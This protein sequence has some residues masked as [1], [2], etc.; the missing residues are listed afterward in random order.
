MKRII[1][2]IG[3][4]LSKT[5]ARNDPVATTSM[6]SLC[7][8]CRKI[9]DAKIAPS[10]S[11]TASIGFGAHHANA[12]QCKK[13]ADEGCLICS[14]VWAKA[15]ELCSGDDPLATNLGSGSFS[16]W[17]VDLN[18]DE[19]NSQG[20]WPADRLVVS[21]SL[22]N[23][24]MAQGMDI[25]NAFTSS[26]VHFGLQP[27]SELSEVVLGNMTSTTTSS[28]EC[29]NQI[30]RWIGT[31]SDTCKCIAK[32]DSD[33]PNFYSPTRLL[34]VEADQGRVYL[35]LKEDVVKDACYVTLS[36]CWGVSSEA[37][38]YR[39][40][41]TDTAG[42][43]RPGISLSDAQKGIDINLLPRTFRDAIHIT[44]RM[45][46][47]YLWIDSLCI[48]QDSSEDWE[49]EA[50]VMHLVYM[51]S[52]L[53]IA[54]DGSSDSEGGIY[55]T[56]NPSA[57][58]PVIVSP[59]WNRRVQRNTFL[60]VPVDFWKAMVS[61]S[62]L[63]RRSWCL[64]ERFLSPAVLHFGQ[65]QVA[66]EC[67]S[68]EAC[69]TFPGGI[70]DS[71]HDQHGR[72]KSFDLA[73][74]GRGLREN[75][76]KRQGRKDDES[77]DRS[78]DKYYLWSRLIEKY[79][80]TDITEDKDK[81]IAIYGMGRFM[82]LLLDDTYIGGLW[83]DIFPSQLLW[84]ID[85]GYRSAIIIEDESLRASSTPP[86]TRPDARNAPTWSW[87]SVNGPI[88]MPKPLR[89]GTLVD[90]KVCPGIELND[91]GSQKNILLVVGGSL[92]PAVFG[93][94]PKWSRWWLQMSKVGH[95]QDMRSEVASLGL[96]GKKPSKN[97]SPS[98]SDEGYAFGKDTALGMAQPDT[99]DDMPP[100]D[101]E[102]AHVFCLPVI[103]TRKCGK[104]AL[105]R[106][107]GFDICGVSGLLLIPEP[108]Y[109][110]FY[111]RIGVFDLLDCSAADLQI[112]SPV[113]GDYQEHFLSNKT[114][115]D[116]RI[117]LT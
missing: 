47:R 74:A 97:S 35:R 90:I 105:R 20:H 93:W 84:T 40:F 81:L 29:W 91:P 11:S 49:A 112:R 76:W 116:W 83:F 33:D 77:G 58:K 61:E 63:G 14:I 106:D 55:K 21:I 53:T 100:A 39:L 71:L 23:L 70:P 27:T 18:G 7:G 104:Y 10:S 95:G 57:A 109:N 67:R 85:C 96:M 13:A 1:S 5:R 52:Y 69:E 15:S 66:F 75:L 111:R 28:D 8:V 37:P 26:K 92:H 113:D 22:R 44:Q 4:Q 16:E 78:L 86:A 3:G 56:R 48:L 82:Q 80:R 2:A 41:Q 38:G 88:V 94:E 72:F 114:N 68:S 62:Y 42:A 45:G 99:D 30:T 117:M 32:R 19:L 107:I 59:Q 60:L 98:D 79:A 87:A 50:Q 12:E 54:A 73:K 6:D 9:F 36:H 43:E 34:D 25:I 64:Q 24:A 102:V 108:G 103:D 101:V 65:T 17:E 115:D 51:G 110:G 89:K 31:C 46:I